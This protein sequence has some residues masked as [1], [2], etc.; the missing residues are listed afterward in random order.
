MPG[1]QLRRI[2]SRHEDILNASTALAQLTPALH[3]VASE[4]SDLMFRDSTAPQFLIALIIAAESA[5]P[6]NQYSN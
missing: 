1:S 5:R 4:S 3:P 6:V 2:I